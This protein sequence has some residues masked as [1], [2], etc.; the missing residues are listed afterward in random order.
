MHAV[1]TDR[2]HTNLWVASLYVS[3]SHHDFFAHDTT[4]SLS[5]SIAGAIMI[6]ALQLHQGQLLPCGWPTV[7]LPRLACSKRAD[8]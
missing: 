5:K 6:V 8:M 2:S 7:L 3:T 1:L 4:A